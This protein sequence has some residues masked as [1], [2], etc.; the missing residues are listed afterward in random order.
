MVDTSL[1]LDFPS[2]V[3]APKVKKKLFRAPKINRWKA[4]SKSIQPLAQ[5]LLLLGIKPVESGCQAGIST[6]IS[7]KLQ[8]RCQKTSAVRENKN[9]VV[10][11]RRLKG[12]GSATSSMHPS[13]STKLPQHQNSR[14]KRTSLRTK[15]VCRTQNGNNCL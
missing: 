14:I 4:S 3:L 15:S 12:T 2:K 8:I 10:V 13:S 9:A 7:L 5:Q 1:I 6:I 11:T